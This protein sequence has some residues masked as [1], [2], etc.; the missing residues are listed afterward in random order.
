MLTHRDALR[1]CAS[2]Y[3]VRPAL[4]TEDGRALTYAELDELTNR[5]ANALLE[6][7]VRP[8]ARLLWLDQNSVEFLLA[9]FATAKAGIVFS[10]LNY[11]LRPR[12]L[13]PL[14]ALLEPAVVVAGVDY[15]AQAEAA[16]AGR[17]VPVRLV[18]GGEAPGWEPWPTLL[19][20]DPAA[21]T[22]PVDEDDVHEVVFTSGTTGESKGVM[23]SQRKRI[24]DSLASALAFELT[25]DDHLLFFLPQFHVGGASVPNQLLVQGGQVTVLRRYD[26]ARVAAAIERGITYIVGVPAHY[27]LL[28]ESGELDGVDTSRVR[29]CYVG[30]SAATEGLFE[31][32]RRRFPNADLVHGYGSTESGPHTMALR[33]QAFLDHFG[34]LGLP[35]PGT[36]VRVVAEGRDVELGDVGELWVRSD[37]VMDGYLGRPDLTAAAFAEDGW[38][39]TGDLVRRDAEGYFTMVDRLKDMIITGGENVYPREV[40]DVLAAYPGVAEVAVI[41]LADA[42]Y[43]ERVVALVR[44]VPGTPEPPA[45]VL[46]AHV[47]ERLAG[48]KTPKELHYVEDF[49]RTGVGK[50][51]KAELRKRYEAS[52]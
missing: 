52:A 12:E 47:R 17:D 30:G 6:R 19:E 31:E 48:F 11:W 18:L 1:R 32:I 25:R 9:Y 34:A 7:G 36:E 10:A 49:P 14:V 23:R 5:I 24:L 29:G 4:V 21:P 45:G 37:S 20:G 35:V 22:V 38:L 3:G 42:V 40:E 43:E 15:V 33:G 50:I 26:P 2:A 16:C 46:V 44:M 41:G 8:G 39:R 28:F 13:E 27:N 51:A